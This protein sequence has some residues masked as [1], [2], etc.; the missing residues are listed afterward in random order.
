MELDTATSRQLVIIGAPSSSVS[1]ISNGLGLTSIPATASCQQPFCCDDEGWGPLSASRFD[2]TP[3]FLDMLAMTVAVFAIVFGARAVWWLLTRNDEEKVAKNWQTWTELAVVIALVAAT[4]LQMAFQIAN[5]PH[6]WLNDFRLW[7]SILTIAS[8]AVISLVEYLG[9][10]RPQGANSVVIFYWLFVLLVYG[11]KLRSLILRQIYKENLSYFIAF[12]IGHGLACLEFA[13][14]WIIPKKNG[15]NT[16]GDN[17]NECPSESATV[18]STLVFSWMTPM[19]KHGYKQDITED[20]LWNLGKRDTTRDAGNTFQHAW[21]LELERRKN[22]SLWIALFRAF[23][24][25]YVQGALFRTG[26]DIFAFLQPQLLRLLILF[27]HSHREHQQPEQPLVQGAAIALAMF[28]V[29]VAQSLC[30]HQS[31]QRISRTGMRLKSSLISAIYAKSLDLSHASRATISTGDIVNLMA[32]DSQRMQDATQFC[33]H[34]WSAPLQITL[35]M[36]SLYRLLGYS[37]FAGV[38]ILTLMIPINGFITR[39]VQSLQK[40]QIKNKDS[41]ARLIAEVVNNMKSIKLFAWAP[42]FISRIAHIRDNLELSTL[43][44]ISAIQAFSSFVGSVTPSLVAC[45]AFG[46]YVYTQ[47]DPLATEIAFPALAL[48]HLLASPLAILPAVISSVTEASIAVGRL[49]NF[50]TADELQPDAVVRLDAVAEPGEESIS[51]RNGTFAWDRRASKLALESI[52]FSARKGQLSC[53]VGRVGAGKSSLLHALLGDL[54]KV[55]GTVTVHGSTAYVAQQAWVLNASVRDNILFGHRWDPE[56]YDETIKACALLEDFAQL[57]HGDRTEV[58]DRGIA[59]SGGQRARLTLARAVYARADVYLLDDCLSAVDA[60]VGR[61]LI[62]NV[63]GPRGLLRESTRV[64][65]T[66]STPVLEVADAIAWV[67]DGEMAGQGTY[68]QLMTI[69]ED[70]ANLVRRASCSPNHGDAGTQPHI[71]GLDTVDSKNCPI[72]AGEDT[73]EGRGEHFGHQHGHIKARLKATQTGSPSPRKKLLDAERAVTRQTQPSKELS[74]QGGVAWDVYGNYAKAGNLSSLAMYGIVLL[75]AQTA[76]FGGNVWLKHW[77]EVNGDVGSNPQVGRYIGVYVALGIVSACLVMAQNV[78]L[79]LFCSIVASRNL[80]DQMTI[81]IFKAPMSFFETTPA[82]RIL[83]RFSS[84]IYRL[85]ENLP[86]QFNSLFTHSAKGVFILAII[87][88]ATPLFVFVAIPLALLYVYM[89]RYYL[90]AKRGLKRLDSTTRSPVFAHFQESLAGIATI[91]AYRQQGRFARENERRLDANLR[92]YVPSIN[93]NRWLGVRLEFLGSVVILAAAGLA[94]ASLWMEKRGWGGGGGGGGSISTG[95]VGLTISYALQITQLFNS[96]VRLTGE[97][98]TNIVSAERVLEYTR[99]PREAPDIVPHRRPPPGWPAQG[100]VR[101]ADYSTR[102]RADLPL[103]LKNVTL[104]FKPGER[105]GV[106]GRTGAGKTSLALALFRIIEAVRGCVYVGGVDVGTMGLMDLR[107][108]LTIIPQDAPLF[109]GTIR[110]NLDPAGNI[111]DGELWD[112]LEHARLK[113]RVASMSGGLDAKV[114]EGGLN[115]SH[116][117]R[118]LVSLA[119][120]LLSRTN[121]LVLDEAT[122]AVDAE[123]DARLQETLRNGLLGNRTIITVAHRINTVIDSDRVVV[124]DKGEVAEFDTPAALALQKGTFYELVRECGLLESMAARR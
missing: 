70:F 38:A 45:S 100:A 24:P 110:R 101:L 103:V 118:Q 90:G 67:R 97:I 71:D 42:E 35:C 9:H 56:F 89:Q 29:S 66:N 104:D 63:L 122:A 69:G 27:V 50:L 119:R 79:W 15:Y 48:F 96:L 12:C 106:V 59:L 123:T 53:L 25:T 21:K 87:S 64:L 95:T 58:G 49:T 40:Q 80:H 26:A 78:V 111:H 57:P 3:C 115:L 16:L 105:I 77:S 31:F 72:R 34:L 43:R 86:R 107:T 19:M 1:S 102:Y 117:E 8:L 52:T 4:V 81:A 36:A 75:G 22:P 88:S 14:V 20:D 46:V 65:A 82:G 47:P 13:L 61:H 44:K 114:Y 93:A 113:E 28:T 5:H 76:E 6:L 112:V 121:I 37:M 98:E 55:S 74:R 99:L 41:R 17:D 51:V 62:D 85:D 94:T 23:G 116:G 73:D 32:I 108:R 2:F 92:A 39:A 60:H 84:D 54:R 120:A 33:Q 68:R 124:L 83:N 30:L 7:N 11:V 18:F 91:R 10:T 109:E